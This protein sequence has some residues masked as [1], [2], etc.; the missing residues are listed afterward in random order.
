MAH[1]YCSSLFHCV[2]STKERRKII[3]PQM[4]AR[5][6]AY[7]GGIAREHEMKALAVGGMANHAH[8]LLSLPTSLAI[9]NAMRVIK[10]GSSRWVH[11]AC[12]MPGFEWQEGYGAFSIGQSQVGA[13]LAYIGRQNEHHRRR[14]FEA[15]FVSILKKH[16]IEYDPRYVWAD[17]RPGPAGRMRRDV[18]TS[19]DSATLH[20]GLFSILPTGD[21]CR[22][23]L[24]Q[25]P[26]RA[27]GFCYLLTH[28]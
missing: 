13:T 22:A 14:D 9:A 5:V 6:W 25:I 4:Q 1:T 16:D 7:M 11:E 3:V 12:A 21:P 28:A 24:R 17:L 8:I 2:F 20:P 10:S 27:A 19:Q 23:R 18:M 26:W 15:E